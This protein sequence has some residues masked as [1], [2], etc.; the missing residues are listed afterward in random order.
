MNKLT[1]AQ[2][3]LL[4]VVKANPGVTRERLAYLCG[5]DGKRQMLPVASIRK[6]ENMDLLE[7]TFPE[8]VEYMGDPRETYTAK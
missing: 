6:L 5:K 1:K 2:S 8:G 3:F 7:V 4:E